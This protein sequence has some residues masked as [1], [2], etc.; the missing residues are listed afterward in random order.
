MFD[1]IIR[2]GCLIDPR[3]GLNQIGDLAIKGRK[4]AAVGDLSGQEAVREINAAGCY[5]TPGL[6]DFHAHAAYGISDF[7]LPADLVQ[8]PNG[9]TSMVDAGSAGCA[10]FEIFYRHS[11]ANSLMT[12]KSFINV[13][14]AGQL[15]HQ[16]NEN[17]D[18]DLFNKEKIAMLADKY[19]GQIIGLKLRQSKDIVGELGL[20]PLEGA[21]AL[22]EE[23]GLRL[24]VHITD[25]PGEVSET[26]DRLRPGDL[27]CHMYHQKG[28]T[29]L[30]E[31]GKIL[32][33][34]RAAR[35]RGVLFELGH[36]AFN[37][38]GKIAKAAIEQDFL[39]DIISSD[40]SMLSAFK[41][42]TYSF[43]YIL[44]ELLN[45]G[46]SFED[47]LKRCTDNP[48]KLMGIEHDGFLKQGRAADIAILRIVDY[49]VHY[50]DR[51]DNLYEGDHLIKVESTIKEGVQ[52]YRAFDFL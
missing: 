17:V 41:A 32:P 7:S 16:F 26:L 49:P 10:D 35:E 47:I 33:E 40:L 5:V 34:L 51:Y 14:T 38:S 8:I 27:F 48:A 29:I 39:P 23:L 44:S 36:G 12:I 42:P 52:L 11:V 22:G 25:S 1:L 45:L 20:K 9:V 13:A 37:F 24:S 18:P 3:S 2:G 15:T 28:K 19:K 43:S 50:H 21:V 6:I 31:N 4:I 30:D 46:V